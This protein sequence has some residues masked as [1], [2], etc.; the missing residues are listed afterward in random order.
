MTLT[1]NVGVRLEIQNQITPDGECRRETHIDI[2]VNS[3]STIMTQFSAY[4]GN[5]HDKVQ[6]VLEKR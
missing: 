3:K 4:E 1:E 6:C 5:Q 2:Y